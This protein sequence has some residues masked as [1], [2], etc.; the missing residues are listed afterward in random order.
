[1]NRICIIWLRSNYNPIFIGAENRIVKGSIQSIVQS[2]SIST[3]I[4][5]PYLL[6]V[7]EDE[8]N[9]L[10]NGGPII[11]WAISDRLIGIFSIELQLED[12]FIESKAE[13]IL[14]N[15]EY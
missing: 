8:E 3:D 4:V 10:V 6:V 13:A 2:E 12:I 1:M 14:R 7:S 9:V 15:G 5:S 11:E